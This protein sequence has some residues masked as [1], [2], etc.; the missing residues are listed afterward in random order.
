MK[1]PP[2]APK[3]AQNTETTVTAKAE[4][5]QWLKGSNNAVH[6]AYPKV[7]RQKAVKFFGRDVTADDVLLRILVQ[8]H[9]H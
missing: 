6:E 5:I 4:V 8:N 7:D 1:L 3:M 9:E 2:G